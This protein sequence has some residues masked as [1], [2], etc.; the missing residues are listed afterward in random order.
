MWRSIG[1]GRYQ[2]AL[3]TSSIS[4]GRTRV[5]MI[6]S[7]ATAAASPTPNCFTV[8]SPLMMK[9]EKTRIM[10]E[11]AAMITRIARPSPLTIARRW[12]PWSSFSSETRVSR[13]TV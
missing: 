4:A 11:A 5:T 8:G 1:P 7:T 9:L 12:S 2:V 3:P 13:K 6:A 10:I